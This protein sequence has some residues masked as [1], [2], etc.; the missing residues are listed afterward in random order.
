MLLRGAGVDC[1]TDTRRFVV[2]SAP[3]DNT[4][5]TCRLHFSALSNSEARQMRCYNRGKTDRCVDVQK[6][7]PGTSLF[8]PSVPLPPSK[9]RWPCKLSTLMSFY[10]VPSHPAPPPPTPTPLTACHKTGV[11][12]RKR[13]GEAVNQQGRGSKPQECTVESFHALTQRNKTEKKVKE[14]LFQSYNLLQLKD[15][16]VWLY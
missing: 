3:K 7:S 5:Y 10:P 1:E 6:T 12:G 2:A 16:A 9:T 13:K 14:P 15:A 11:I 4:T 8:S